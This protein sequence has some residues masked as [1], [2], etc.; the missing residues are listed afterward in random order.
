MRN[1]F[2]EQRKD[3]LHD[4]SPC[5]DNNFIPLVVL[6]VSPW[7]RESVQHLVV[8]VVEGHTLSYLDQARGLRW[9]RYRIGRM[10]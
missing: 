6:F 3:S 10:T 2:D 8:Y 4:T 5:K 7:Q 1:T 9:K